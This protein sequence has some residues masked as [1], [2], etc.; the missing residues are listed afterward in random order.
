MR[1]NRI[2]YIASHTKFLVDIALAALIPLLI[3]IYLLLAP[4]TKVEESF[5]TQAT[6][7]I[8]TY[9]LPLK[10]DGFKLREPYDHLEFPGSVPRTFVGPLALATASWP[11][12]GLVRGFHRQILGEFAP[13]PG[14]TDGMRK[15]LFKAY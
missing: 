14:D 9:G 1:R 12:L 13:R 15:L 2:E 3:I 5:N 8:L 11:F 7:D 4:Y 6:H 10:S